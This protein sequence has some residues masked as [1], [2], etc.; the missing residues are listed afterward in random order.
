MRIFTA[1]LEKRTANKSDRE[2]AQ[3]SSHPATA[4]IELVA[5][6]YRLDVLA[7]SG[8][9][10]VLKKLLHWYIGDIVSAAPSL[11][12]TGDGVVLRQRKR[13]RI[14]LMFPVFDCTMQIPT[15]RLQVRFRIEKLFHLKAGD[16]IFTRP[17]IS[18]FFTYLHKPAFAVAAMF[19]RIEAAL[20]PNDGFHQ[21]GIKVMFNRDAANQR[22]ILL[23]PRRTH[24]FVERVNR[25]SRSHCEISK[26][27]SQCQ[28]HAE[29][30]FEEE[31]YHF[32]SCYN[33]RLR[34]RARA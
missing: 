14:G 17:F 31:S 21:H 5:I 7:R 13:E 9:I 19:S 20:A 24:P 34:L 6:D 10:D 11:G 28:Q 4:L 29:D 16:L 15:A 8:K 32:G 26:S 18:R 2:S 22:I 1:Q 12:A 30:Q 23:K 27:C 3:L 33:S 25:I